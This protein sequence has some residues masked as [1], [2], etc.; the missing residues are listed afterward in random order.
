MLN[1]KQPLQH[2]EPSELCTK[3]KLQYVKS[4]EFNSE[5]QSQDVK[6][7]LGLGRELPGTQSL[8]LNLGPQLQGI[9]PEVHTEIKLTDESSMESKHEPKL[10]GG[11]SCESS[12]GPQSH[13]KK[14]YDVQH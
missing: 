4:M 11:K 8:Q 14:K 1:P 3:T 2:T 9:K 7:E 10:H 5:Q 13:Y 6:S 12:P